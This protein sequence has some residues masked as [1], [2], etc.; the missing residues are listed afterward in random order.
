VPGRGGSL[1]FLQSL[2]EGDG[3]VLVSLRVAGHEE[4][5]GEVNATGGLGKCGGEGGGE[6]GREG[7]DG[8]EGG[9]EGGGREKKETPERPA[10]QGARNG[11]H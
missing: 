8:E 3:L 10:G 4:I 9:R 7:E 2:A 11:R 6:G 1:P 5:V